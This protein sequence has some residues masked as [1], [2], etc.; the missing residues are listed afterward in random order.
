MK[1]NK[2]KERSKDNK[3]AQQPLLLPHHLLTLHPLTPEIR[4]KRRRHLPLLLL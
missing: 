4:R 3:G 1:K 2:K